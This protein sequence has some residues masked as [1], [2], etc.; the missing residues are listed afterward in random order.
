MS[1]VPLRW[2]LR[3]SASIDARAR[4]RRNGRQGARRAQRVRR[5]PLAHRAFGS[6]RIGHL[7][8]V[9]EQRLD[10][11]VEGGSDVAVVRRR[12]NAG[13]QP[14]LVD[15]VRFESLVGQLRMRPAVAGVRDTPRRASRSRWRGGPDA[16]RRC[17]RGCVPGSCRP[18]VAG[19][20][21]G[22]SAPDR[23]AVRASVPG[24]RR[25]SRGNERRRRR[26]RLPPPV[27]RRAATGP[28]PIAGSRA[29]RRPRRRR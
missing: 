5:G 20:R 26:R 28:S 16:R 14:D 21:C 10:L 17:G 29:R 4:P 3:G 13:R 19:G 25:G 24:G 15:R 8:L 2:L 6:G 11:A 18:P 23:V 7:A 27:A 22:S 12:R 1:P 9:R